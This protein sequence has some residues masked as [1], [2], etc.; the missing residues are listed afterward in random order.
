MRP[1]YQARRLGDFAR[2]LRLGRELAGHEGW[3]RE[4]FEVSQ[5]AWLREI[6]GFAGARSPF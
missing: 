6:I 4:R 5:T 3:S 1:R 2:G